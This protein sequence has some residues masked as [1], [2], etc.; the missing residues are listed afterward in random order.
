M[1][2][3]RD[4][5]LVSTDPARLDVDAIHAFLRRSYWARDLDRE[6]VARSLAGSLCF[7][8]YHDGA[9]V[10]LARVVTDRAT[11]AYLCDV[12]VREEHQHQGL[13]AWLMTCV[14]EHEDL[15][16]LRRFLL[17]TADA[18]AFYHRFGFEP[19]TRPGRLLEISAPPEG[20]QPDD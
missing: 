4:G 7:G 6:R 14:L 18:H 17:H 19:P 1:E 11:F 9:Q 5:Y 12:Y 13:G 15:Q 2:R 16:D 20:P 10:G 8:L 3:E